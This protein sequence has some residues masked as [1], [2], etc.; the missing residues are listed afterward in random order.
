[1][2]HLSGTASF[3]PGLTSTAQ[4]FSYTFSGTLDT[5]QSSVSGAPAGGSV[6]TPAPASGNGSCSSSTTSGYS[7]SNWADGKQTVVKYTT[8]GA[9]ALVVLQGTVVTSAVLGGTTYA[10]DEPSTP[11]GNSAYGE[12]TF[13]TQS[14]TDIANCASGGLGTAV[15][16]GF[17]EIGQS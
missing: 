12:L 7:V 3:T 9:G 10:T 13:S 14:P 16:N 2:C 17:I 6:G 11:V 1:M 4:N 5:C 8:T 15:I